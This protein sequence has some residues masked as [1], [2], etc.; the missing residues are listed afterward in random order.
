MT[1]IPKEHM[2]SDGKA[3]LLIL[4]FLVAGYSSSQRLWETIEYRV[5]Y[6]CQSHLQSKVIRIIQSKVYL[7]EVF[8]LKFR[9]ENDDAAVKFVAHQKQYIA[10]LCC[11]DNITHQLTHNLFKDR[12]YL[13]PEADTIANAFHLA[14]K[15][16]HSIH[17]K[18]WNQ[19]RITSSYANLIK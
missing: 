9:N 12:P 1:L 3:N 13:E 17:L 5:A 19:L 18:R 7:Y 15:L 10:L 8:N 14:M 2:R 16:N 4:I 11:K 6:L